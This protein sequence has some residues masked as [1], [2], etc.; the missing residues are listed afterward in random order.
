MELN[1]QVA[2]IELVE[3]AE[4]K[5]RLRLTGANG[6]DCVLELEPGAAV[7]F[8]PDDVEGG[9]EL[10]EGMKDLLSPP[11]GEGAPE[12]AA[13]PPAR[14]NRVLEALGELEPA[15]ATHPCPRMRPARGAR[16]HPG[17]GR[18]PLPGVR[19]AAANRRRD[20]PAPGRPS[21]PSLLLLRDGEAPERRN[22]LRQYS[23][24][25][26]PRMRRP[27]LLAGDPR[28]AGQLS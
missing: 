12:E 14:R 23:H 3:T 25:P 21:G 27:Q 8:V 22:P 16:H 6:E 1:L 13:P 11:P 9:W 18:H 28:P 24:L 10:A 19:P 7:D 5:A 17:G 26:E 20:A 2:R 15:L 4:G